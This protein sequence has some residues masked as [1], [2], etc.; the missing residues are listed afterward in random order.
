MEKIYRTFFIEMFALLEKS[1]YHIFGEDCA[2]C[3][4]APPL[5]QSAACALG[6]AFIPQLI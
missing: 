3:F 2:R 5:W 6:M 1:V 4:V